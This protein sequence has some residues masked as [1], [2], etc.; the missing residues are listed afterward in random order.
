VTDERAAGAVLALRYDH[1]VLLA[2]SGQESGQVGTCR[3]D[4]LYGRIAVGACGSSAQVDHFYRAG[5][6]IA[7]I[8]VRY[9][10]QS[11]VSARTLTFA[12]ASTLARL[13]A[14]SPR[15]PDVQL[16]VA[17]ATDLHEVAT[18][19]RVIA[20][21]RCAAIGPDADSVLEE[22]SRA[23]SGDLDLDAACW[24]ALDALGR[25]GAGVELAGIDDRR[26]GQGFFRV[27]ADLVER[28]RGSRGRAA[29]LSS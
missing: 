11:D 16:L 24:I 13:T 4:S 9:R 28:A 18:D 17:D 3:L 20:I 23:A 21:D 1:G 26:T 7:D 19:G 5:R 15:R 27:P 25:R 22:V 29:G 2:A 14:E 10:Q 12:Y 8:R 6:R